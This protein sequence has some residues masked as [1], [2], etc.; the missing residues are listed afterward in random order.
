M[1]GRSMRRSLIYLLIIVAITAIVFTL[2]SD[3]V[4]GSQEISINEVVSLAAR[5]DLAVIEIRGNELDILTVSGEA[6]TS[7]K[8]AEA[9]VVELLERAGVDP[10]TTKIEIVVKGSSGLSSLFGIL[11]NFLPLIFFGAILLFMM[12]QAQGNS[13]QTFSFGRSRARVATGNGPTVSF[14]DVAGVEEAKEELLEVVE[15]LKFPERFLALGAKIPK[16]VLLIGPPGTGKTLM[17][18]AVSGEAGVP[19]FSI[20]GSEFVEMFVGVGAS[21]VRD[22]F[23]QAKRNSPCIVFVDEIDAVG[24]HRGAGLGGGHDEREQTLNQIL[25]EMDGFDTATNVI[26]LA[27]TNRPDIL[28]PALLRPGRFDRRVTLDNPDIRGRKQI[29]EVHSKGKPLSADVDLE[30][31]A[32][33][34]VGFSGADLANLVNESAIL[35][36]RQN[37]KEIGP[38]E[39]YESID[40][41]TAGPAR[42][43][44][45][46]NDREKRMTAYHESGHALVAHMLP[47]AD[48][49][50]KVTIVA[51]GHSGGFTKTI[52]TED[53]SLI[54]RNQLEARL[55]MAMGGRVAEELVFGEITTGASNDLEQATNIAQT[56]VTRYGMSKKLGPRTFGKREEMVFL[57]REI[58]EQRDYS[59]RVAKTIDEEVRRLI[60]TAYDTAK[61]ILTEER[62]RLDHI[63]DYLLEHE[64]ID[65]EQV[66]DLFDA[67]FDA[68]PAA[69]MPPVPAPVP[70]D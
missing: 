48:P 58:S 45:R 62:V 6:L 57:G 33:Q 5:G 38:Q 18:R 66:P 13:N 20:S 53:R 42:K 61:R 28:D 44:R 36:A 70:G 22:L 47:E 4:G 30:L 39:F 46:I 17:A 3:S 43:S 37:Q 23:D 51:R 40:R 8:E 32:R 49:V 16:G 24:R 1:D 26:V 67:P 7:R 9:S 65:E 50:A 19:F 55:A 14:D 34:T 35:A 25:V 10:L 15:F 54:T 29:L 60:Q 59:D 68:P 2:F 31:V 27:A 12:R 63:S 11:F 69:G 64:T 52:P 41:V 56:M 21:R